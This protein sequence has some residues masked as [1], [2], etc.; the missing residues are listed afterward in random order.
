VNETIFDEIREQLLLLEARVHQQTH[1]LQQT[2]DQLDYLQQIAKNVVLDPLVP[3][4]HC[5]ALMTALRD[6]GGFAGDLTLFPPGDL[7]A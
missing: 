1:L 2:E 6:T 3:D 4:G 7:D 5:E